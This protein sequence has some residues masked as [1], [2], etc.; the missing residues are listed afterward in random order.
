[1]IYEDILEELTSFEESMAPLLGGDFK[2]NH[3]ELYPVDRES[4]T[5]ITEDGEVYRLYAVTR[6]EVQILVYKHDSLI[7]EELESLFEAWAHGY[8]QQLDNKI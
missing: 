1:M 8:H 2:V 5:V 3:G 7:V 4:L 6:D